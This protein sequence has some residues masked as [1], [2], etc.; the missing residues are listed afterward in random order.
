MSARPARSRAA[1]VVVRRT[2]A[3]LELRV[4]GTHASQLRAGQLSAGPVWDALGAALLALPAGRRRRL[5]ILGLGGGTVAGLYRAL[6]PR[7]RIIGVEMDPAVVRAARRH[8]GLD[9]LDLEIVVRDAISFL[10]RERRRFDLLVEDCFV[11]PTRTIH[12]PEGFPE[13]VLRL[14]ARR[15]SPGGLLVAN[16]IHEPAQYRR[17]LRRLLPELL[18]ISVAGFWN[19]ILI[20][21]RQRLDVRALRA[22]V[23]ASPLRPSLR[24]LSF[25]RRSRPRRRAT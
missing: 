22:A 20:A 7:A 1:G 8:F 23:E 10:R 12:K 11:G 3:G 19:R 13:P 18:E 15:L 4:G 17:A 2:P 9:A 24:R 25:R 14:A 6:A 16:T 5:G 21:S